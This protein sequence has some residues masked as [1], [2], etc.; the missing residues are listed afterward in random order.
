[1]TAQDRS[2]AAVVA[3][4]LKKLYPLPAKAPAAPSAPG[5]ISWP[6]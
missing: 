1:M 4:A 6:K 5:A 3:A 2:R